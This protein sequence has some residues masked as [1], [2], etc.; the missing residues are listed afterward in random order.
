[1]QTQAP[2]VICSAI[3]AVTPSERMAAGHQINIPLAR[4]Q[5][6]WATGHR[7]ATDGVPA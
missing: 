2:V 6:C 4:W 1:M 5:T 7:L 3:L